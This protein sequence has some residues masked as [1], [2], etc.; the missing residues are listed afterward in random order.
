MKKSDFKRDNI[1]KSVFIPSFGEHA[2]ISKFTIT[3]YQYI[4]T[5]VFFNPVS[6]HGQE[7]DKMDFYLDVYNNVD[8]IK[9]IAIL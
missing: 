5:I 1:G 9:Q 4:V 6:W 8:Q 7:F 3:K 2:Q